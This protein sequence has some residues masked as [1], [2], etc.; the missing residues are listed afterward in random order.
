MRKILIMVDEGVEDVEFLYPYYRLQEEG[1]KLDIVASKAKK[2]TLEN[3]AFHS[4]RTS[5]QRRRTSTNTKV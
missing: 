5:N 1:Y 2:P 4:R 3:M